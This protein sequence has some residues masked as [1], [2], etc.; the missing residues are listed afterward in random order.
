M[1]FQ[2]RTESELTLLAEGQQGTLFTKLGAMI[3]YQG[4]FKFEKVLLDTNGG[5]MAA[6]LLRNIGRRLTG[7]NMPLAKVTGS[8]RC[9]FA[10]MAQHV[11]VINLQQG[12]SIGVESEN[13]LAFNDMCKYGIRMIGVGVISQKGLFTSTLTGMGPGAQ[14]AVLSDGNPLILQSPCTV[15]PD[16]IVCWT[17]GDPGL[18]LDLNW[19][20]FI[21]QASGESYALEFKTQG[22]TVIVQPNERGSGLHIGVDDNNYRPEMQQGPNMQTPFGGGDQGG[23]LLGGIGNLF[24]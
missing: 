14:V 2:L 16:A 10:D 15:D 13:L 17:G 19:K 11:V 20:S 21:G 12:Q 18:K 22:E 5:N 4:Q 23:G 1:P 7:E 24:R 8:G 3:A 6:S 9:F